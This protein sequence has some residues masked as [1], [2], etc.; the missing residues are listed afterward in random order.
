MA[1]KSLFGR[2][3]TPWLVNVALKVVHCLYLVK[4][5]WLTPD[6]LPSYIFGSLIREEQHCGVI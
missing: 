1:Y 3:V 4:E 2:N 6:R 5:M